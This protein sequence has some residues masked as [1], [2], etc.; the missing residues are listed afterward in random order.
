MS[1]IS[2]FN[3]SPSYPD[4][5]DM[6]GVS[7]STQ[8]ALSEVL[9]TFDEALEL[10]DQNIHDANAAKAAML[11]GMS[12][13]AGI[14][15]SVS[16]IIVTQREDDVSKETIRNSLLNQFANAMQTNTIPDLLRS[17]TNVVP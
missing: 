2:G 10:L 16:N 15:E 12:A 13:I 5:D 14:V 6:D 11:S 8:T 17:F 9:K 4:G 7:E 3:D 1:R